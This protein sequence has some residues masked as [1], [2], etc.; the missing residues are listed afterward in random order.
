MNTEK[1]ICKFCGRECKN[2]NSL[3]NHERLCKCNPS[4]QY[5][6]FNGIGFSKFHEDVKNGLRQHSTKGKI[7]I[8]KENQQKYIFKENMDIYLNDGW[9]LGT[10]EKFKSNM[11]IINRRR[12]HPG[13][14]NTDKGEEVRKKKISETMKKNPL[15]G[16]YRVGSGRGK[17]G[18]YKGVF[19]DSSWELAFLFYHL[20][21][22]LNIERCKEK[23]QYVF[24]GE[25][26]KYLPDFI[27]D[28]G[29]VEIKGFKTKQ[30]ESKIKQNPDVKVLYEKDMEKYLEYVI[31]RFGNT[32]WEKLYE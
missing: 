32:F 31:S 2:Q 22:G 8:H 18:W 13:K 24:N 9:L 23:R 27:T 3:R 19:C 1:F 11:K 29:I 30:W 15:S 7:C 21:Q 28:E 26:H 16:G 14:A 20:D 17:K 10:C 4:R 12:L 6:K 5:V 25:M